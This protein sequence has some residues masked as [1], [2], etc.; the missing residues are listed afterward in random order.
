MIVLKRIIF[1]IF[2]VIFFVSC[3]DDDSSDYH[4]ELLVVE[5]ALV[6][7]EF[8]FGEIYD[9]TVKYIAPDNCYVNSDILYEYDQDARNVAV[10]SLV[11]EDYNCDVLDLEQDLT[12]KVHALQTSPYIFRFWQGDDESGEPTYLIVEVPVI[13]LIDQ[14]ANEFKETHTKM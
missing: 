4:Y 7:E 13:N 9:L 1:V 10:I 11:V 2:A 8:V 12:F 6:P 5:D 14:N 3:S